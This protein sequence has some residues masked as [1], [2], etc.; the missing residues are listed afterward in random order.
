MPKIVVRALGAMRDLTGS[1][2]VEVQIGEDST[3]G[4]ALKLLAKKRGKVLEDRIFDSR[5][6]K[7]RPDIRLLLN[8]QNIALLKGL[9]TPVKDRDTITIFHPAGGG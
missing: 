1:R 2:E 4:G 6:G 7:L 9:K 8:G 5:T 3:I